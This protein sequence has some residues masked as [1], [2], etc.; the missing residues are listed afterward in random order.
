VC[1]CV[2]VFLFLLLRRFKLF[3]SHTRNPPRKKIISPRESTQIT[4][5]GFQFSFTTSS[6]SSPPFDNFSLLCSHNLITHF[7][8]S[9]SRLA[10]EVRT[11]LL[12][13]SNYCF[14]KT[15]K[16]FLNCLL[17]MLTTC[18][19]KA[20]W[21]A[22][23]WELPRGFLAI[24]LSLLCRTPFSQHI[25][26]EEQLLEEIHSNFFIHSPLHKYHLPELMDVKLFKPNI[27]YFTLLPHSLPAPIEI[28]RLSSHSLTYTHT[29]WSYITI[30]LLLEEG[31]IPV[32]CFI[33][34]SSLFLFSLSLQ[35][36]NAIEEDEN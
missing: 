15:V 18:V 17:L 26:V 2:C 20:L 36:E 19:E 8:I 31:S 21:V 3:C 9:V 16:Y 7:E 13:N 24:K 4:A 14:V 29:W 5:C 23:K 27:S 1:V 10:V 25:W 11:P 12:L 30:I 33:N 34:F 22:L 32:I 35:N 28:A 6:L